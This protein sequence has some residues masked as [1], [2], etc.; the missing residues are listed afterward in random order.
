MQ[1]RTKNKIK[2]L[3]VLL[4]ACALLTLV[5]CGSKTVMSVGE[6]SVSEN[7][8]EFFMSRMKGLLELY[9]S[10]VS[11]SSFWNTVIS[12]D[13]MTV[14]EY[15]ST[16]VLEQVSQYA[17]AQYL[18]DREGLELSDEDIA[19]IDEI[20]KDYIKDAG[21]KNKLNSILSQC[22]V[23]ADMLRDIYLGELKAEKLKEHLYG[24]DCSKLENADVV[25]KEYLDQNYVCFKQIFIATYYYVTETDA[26][27]DTVYYTD[28]SAKHIAYDKEKG[29]TRA[30]VYDP[31][32]VE[33]DKFGDP[34]YYLENGRIAYDTSGIPVYLK[35]SS[36]ERRIAE[37]SQKKKDELKA[38]ADSLAKENRTAS[39]FEELINKHSEADNPEAR[40]Y[41]RR[42]SG[43]YEA[44]GMYFAYFDEIAESLTQ[45]GEGESRVIDS[46]AGYHVIYK[47][48]NEEKAYEDES[49]KDTFASFYSDLTEKLFGEECKK[50]E[51]KISL[52]GDIVAEL[53]KMREVASNTLY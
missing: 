14:D 37:Y 6:I 13:G 12:T 29:S 53:P 20:I 35:D 51:D 49:Y 26:K 10:D 2:L 40:I 3:A 4:C 38:F 33:R 7:E 42:E 16:L 19:D 22:G 46:G 25:K 28:E 34:V 24:A 11:S 31:S 47:Y 44:Q 48:D 15:Y 52:E 45:M 17:I 8:V 32:E 18:F 27:G 41:L 30:D 50:H 39:E 43:Y 9:G 5:S 1:K 21:S 36:G 23:N